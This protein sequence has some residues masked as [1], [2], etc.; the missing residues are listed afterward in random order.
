MPSRKR[1]HREA[2]SA[3]AEPEQPNENSLIHKLRNSFYFANLYQWICIFGK[4]VKLDD[5]MDIAVRSRPAQCLRATKIESR[6][7]CALLQDLETECL[8]HGSMALQDIGLTL[9]KHISS[10]RGLTYVV[11]AIP[12]FHG[13]AGIDSC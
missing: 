10:H 2:D 1:S 12:S 3:T 6:T 8:K 9:L 11:H 7:D 5:N 13:D 4:V